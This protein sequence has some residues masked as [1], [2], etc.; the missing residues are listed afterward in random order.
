MRW[1]CSLLILGFLGL[2]QAFS[3]SGSRVLV[4][5]EE[6]AD[7]NKFSKFWADLTGR[8]FQLAFESPKN[9]KLSLFEHGARAY[10]HVILL[11][12][13]SKGL[14]PA[15]TPK[16]ILDF[17]NAEG[18]IL[19]TLSAESPT[20]SAITSLLLE[21][22]IQLPQEKA[23]LVVDHF[24]YD[25]LSASEKHDVVLV[26]RPDTLREGAANFFKGTGQGGEYIAFP[27]GLG[28]TLGN[29]NPLLTPVL[30]APRT[31]YSYNPKE[32]SEGVEEPFAV[33]KQLSLVSA[34][35]A[36]NSARF[37]L[38]GSVEMLENT[39]FDAKIKRSIGEMQ[40]GRDAKKQ[41]TSNRAFAEEISAWTFKEIGVVK[42]G[43]I[44]H[45][46]ATAGRGKGLSAVPSA[47]LN[48][49]IY[50]VKN[51]VTY[52]I[53]ISQ[54]N[55]DKYEPFT[56]PPGDDLQLEFSMLSPFQRLNLSPS[57][58]TSNSTI[59]TSSF[60]VPDQH[61]IF[62]FRVNYKRPFL[63]Y[64]NE[65]R[66]VTVRHFAHDEWPRS[67]QI[68]G[69]WVWIAGVWTTVLVWLAFVG[70]WLYSE[71]VKEKTIKKIQ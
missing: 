9:E 57:I 7:K 63:T 54:Y 45:H 31:S 58:T 69:G 24:N 46:L 4:V 66:T 33:G 1:I 40:V 17:V 50:R 25:L 36:R 42:V 8:G 53:E 16:A 32:E 27:R 62:H 15:L 44:E 51:D 12:P 20:P 48:P 68:S 2:V 52:S 71:P 59:F 23:S 49:K 70:I 19:L 28:H 29:S 21:F 35:Q 67:W 61:G 30:R 56:L 64:I 5:Q 41:P 34:L 11:P 47:E 38:L 18:N 3:T 13:K 22:E 14:G 10:D 37:T 26:P 6:A 43:Q 55:Y 39:W 65:K 60:T